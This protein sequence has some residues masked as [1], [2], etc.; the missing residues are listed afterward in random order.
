MTPESAK[1]ICIEAHKGQFRRDR[2][3]P[4]SQHPIAV[5]EL[6]STDDEQILGYLHDI[7]EDTDW[8]LVDNAYGW[9]LY[10]P[11]NDE[12]P[13]QEF[14]ISE[15]QY[16]SLDLLTRK[17]NQTYADYITAISGSHLTTKVKIADIFINLP[18]ATK[19]AKVK[20][21]TALKK[22]LETL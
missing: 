8:I 13:Y 22:L 18:T 4:Y 3:T 15:S 9:F 7:I 12:Q 5:A 14:R 19:T 6:L 10:L 21:Y 11:K 16:N 1:Q 20:Y 2:V 17:L